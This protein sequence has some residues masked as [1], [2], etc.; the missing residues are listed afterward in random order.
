MGENHAKEFFHDVIDVVVMDDVVPVAN[1]N[2][3]S[4]SDVVAEGGA[5][6]IVV[7]AAPFPERVGDAV[8]INRQTRSEEK[9]FPHLFGFPIVVIEFRLNGTRQKDRGLFATFQDKVNDLFGEV[10]VPVVELFDRHGAVDPREM[11]HKVGARNI[12][13][14]LFFVRIDVVSVYDDAAAFQSEAK[15]LPDE[16]VSPRD[17]DVHAFFLQTILLTT[18]T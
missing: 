1:R 5:G 3:E 14:K 6:G 17:E 16:T 7:G 15:V 18:P 12:P 4:T 9:I 10:G 8:N 11:G 2:R 13:A